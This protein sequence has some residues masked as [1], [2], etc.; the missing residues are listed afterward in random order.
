[1]DFLSSL[2]TYPMKARKIRKVIRTLIAMTLLH[3]LLVVRR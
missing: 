3:M 2:E 1:V